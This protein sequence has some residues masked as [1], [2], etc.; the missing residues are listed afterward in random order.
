MQTKKIV[1]TMNFLPIF[2]LS[3]D[4]FW[5][6]QIF[7]AKD[8]FRTFDILDHTFGLPSTF[9]PK[10]CFVW[11]I[12]H[13]ARIVLSFQNLKH[14]FLSPRYF[15]NLLGPKFFHTSEIFHGFSGLVHNSDMLIVLD[16]SSDMKTV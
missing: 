16:H 6:K 7:R 4:F 9:G 12:L 3:K 5:T 2:F 13:G 11:P 15:R 8:Y 1:L 14:D 10:F